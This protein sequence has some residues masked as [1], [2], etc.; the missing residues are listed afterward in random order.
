MKEKIIKA[1][2]Y[3][4]TIVGVLLFVYFVSEAIIHEP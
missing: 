2:S 1:F 4:F 3:S